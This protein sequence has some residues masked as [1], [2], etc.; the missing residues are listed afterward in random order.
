MTS[1]K[2][3][4]KKAQT[5]EERF[6]NMAILHFKTSIQQKTK[7]RRVLKNNSQIGFLNM[8]EKHIY[9]KELL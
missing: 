5:T 4:S 6:I 2:D 1:N 8:L 9:E 7:M 3:F